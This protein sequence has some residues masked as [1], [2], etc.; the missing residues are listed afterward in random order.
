MLF[1]IAGDFLRRRRRTVPRASDEVP[2]QP[3]IDF[4]AFWVLLSIGAFCAAIDAF[5]VLGGSTFGISLDRTMVGGVI[6]LAVV[7]F[8]CIER[9]LHF[10]WRIRR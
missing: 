3:L 10:W 5:V 7:A 9:A 1:F 6:A 2:L 8:V 4:V